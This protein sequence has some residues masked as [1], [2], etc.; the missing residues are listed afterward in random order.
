MSARAARARR[1][2]VTAW[3]LLLLSVSAWPIAD[4]SI[5]WLTAAIAGLPLLLP[6]PGLLVGSTRALRA[7]ALALA[8]ALVVAVTET[9]INSSARAWTGVSLALLFA[10]FAALVAAIRVAPKP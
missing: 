7:S 1:I 5:G 3:L 6:L 9:L 4:S 10:A 2:A 8:P